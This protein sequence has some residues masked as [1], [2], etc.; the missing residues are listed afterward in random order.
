MKED[1]KNCMQRRKAQTLAEVYAPRPQSSA[2]MYG[3]VATSLSA[4]GLVM[5]SKFYSMQPFAHPLWIAVAAVLIF[6]S[7]IVV[8]MGLVRRYTTAQQNEYNKMNLKQ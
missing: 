7:S 3:I 4:V 6:L 1:M 5:F 2:V 8:Q